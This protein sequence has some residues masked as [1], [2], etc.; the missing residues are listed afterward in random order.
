MT[1]RAMSDP[2][3]TIEE[4]NLL[5]YQTPHKL[6]SP[7][8]FFTRLTSLFDTRRA[9]TH[10]SIYLTQKRRTTLPSPSSK[11]PQSLTST[12]DPPIHHLSLL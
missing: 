6:T 11:Q 8:Q 9:S 7:L 10:G 5:P 3:L 2:H 4:V 1:G 12:S